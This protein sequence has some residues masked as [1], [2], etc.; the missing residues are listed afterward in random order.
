MIQDIAPHTFDN[1]FQK[2]LPSPESYILS[3]RGKEALSQYKNDQIC[4]P[5]AKELDLDLSQAIYLFSIDQDPYFLVMHVPEQNHYAY[6]ELRPLTRSKPH[7][8]GF[9]YATGFHLYDWYRNRRF[10]GRCGKA[11]GCAL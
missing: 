1:A 7:H 6:H 10:C 9:A 5:R 8:F 4:C 2:I 3:F 11:G